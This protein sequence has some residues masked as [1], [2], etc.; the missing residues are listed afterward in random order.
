[1]RL[2]LQSHDDRNGYRIPA[3]DVQRRRS[4]IPRQFA[5]DRELDHVLYNAGHPSVNYATSDHSNYT[6]EANSANLYHHAVNAMPMPEHDDASPED[7]ANPSENQMSRLLRTQQVCS[8]LLIS[9]T[10]FSDT[11][12]SSQK[13]MM[14]PLRSIPCLWVIEMLHNP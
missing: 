8:Y 7:R 10:L 12:L 9:G 13:T 4:A 5:N 3:S 11:C 1:M 14:F 2:A 6:Y